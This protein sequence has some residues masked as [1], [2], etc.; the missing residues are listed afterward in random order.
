MKITLFSFF[1]TLIIYSCSDGQKPDIET[2]GG[3]VMETK[4]SDTCECRELITDSTGIHYLN[5]ELYTGVCRE[6]YPETESKYIDKNL[7]KGEL[8]GEVTYYGKSGKILFQ[9][10][11]K[12]G[13]KKRSG[14]IDAISCKCSEL[15]KVDSPLKSE[16]SRFLLDGIPFTG[17]CESYYP[18]SQQKYMQLDYKNGLQHG[19]SIYYKKD[20]STLY[21]ETYEHGQLVSTIH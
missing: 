6:Y 17:T 1:L 3:T 13:E 7:L 21:I 15:E 14:E 11:Y 2:D 18:E 12:N 8:H 4:L 16:G 20:G 5:G 9:E 19:R 10:V